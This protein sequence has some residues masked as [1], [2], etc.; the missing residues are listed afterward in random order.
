MT[1][2]SKRAT[3]LV[4][5]LGCLLFIFLGGILYFR[6]REPQATAFEEARKAQE[7]AENVLRNAPVRGPDEAGVLIIE[8]GDFQCPYCRDIA[9]LMTQIVEE[10]PEDVRHLW[11]HQPNA[12]THAESVQA[13]VAARCAQQQGQFWPYHDKLFENQA[14]LSL[15]LM[16]QIASSLQLDLASFQACL[17]SEEARTLITQNVTFAAA[18]GVDATP[19]LLINDEAISGTIDYDRLR[20][21]IERER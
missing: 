9:P 8:F 11:I 20:A 3:N 13:A 14:E 12:S 2:G 1:H 10:Y 18:V 6:L 4:L 21:I 17:G 19:Y 7:L 16:N 5:W 15:A